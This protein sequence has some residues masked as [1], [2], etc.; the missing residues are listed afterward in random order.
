MCPFVMLLN[1]KFTFKRN[2]VITYIKDMYFLI[3]A[4]T[5]HKDGQPLQGMTL[6]EKEV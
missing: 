2:G 4:F 1:F 3:L 5:P 6:Q